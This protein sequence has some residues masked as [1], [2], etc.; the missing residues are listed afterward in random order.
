MPRYSYKRRDKRIEKSELELMLFKE[1]SERIR[2]LV[3]ALYLS[4]ARVSEVLEL[5]VKN[6]TFFS[7]GDVQIHMITL[8]RERKTQK[9]YQE[10]RK[11]MFG[12]DTPFLHILVG[13]IN[14]IKHTMRF[15]PQEAWQEKLLFKF[16]KDPEGNRTTVNRKL[17][18]LSSVLS[19]HAFRHSRLQ[20]LADSGATIA[21][22]KAW[23]GHRKPDTL[24]EY[25]EASKRLTEPL[26][27]KID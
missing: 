1:K 25:V 8:K 26:K 12:K 11:L 22:M 5:R 23:S 16:C 27:D 13:Y 7:N 21:Q 14:K 3:V 2:A 9:P 24:F 4:G 15:L 6:F 10:S 18:K 19:P 17:K 20:K